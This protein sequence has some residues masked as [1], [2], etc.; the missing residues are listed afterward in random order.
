LVSFSVR[1]DE[2]VH[3]YI[4]RMSLYWNPSPQKNVI[5]GKFR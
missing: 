2:V 5:L 4:A 3:T 1:V